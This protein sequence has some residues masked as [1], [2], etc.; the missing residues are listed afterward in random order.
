MNGV[1]PVKKKKI[2]PT[3]TILSEKMPNFIENRIYLMQCTHP[4]SYSD[5]VYF[6]LFFLTSIA[7]YHNPLT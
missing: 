6:Y 3:N 7:G 2:K 5:Y 1:T 4:V